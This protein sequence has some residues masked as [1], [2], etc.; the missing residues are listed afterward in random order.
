[1]Y[2]LNGI[3]FKKNK[4]F[5]RTDGWMDERTDGRTDGRSDYI[6]PQILFGGIKNSLAVLC[7]QKKGNS[8]TG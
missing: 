5:E 2:N 4:K 7:K 8:H 6:M 1:M 3:P